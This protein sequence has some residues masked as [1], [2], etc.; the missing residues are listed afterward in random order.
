MPLAGAPPLS[1]S[2]TYVYEFVPD[3]GVII[4]LVTTPV[5][6][7]VGVAVMASVNVAVI[8]TVLEA[9]NKLSASVSVRV[10]V[11]LELHTPHSGCLEASFAHVV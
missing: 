4:T 8:V 11:T 6:E 7:I 3:T 9:A 2:Q 1:T 10:T 5:I